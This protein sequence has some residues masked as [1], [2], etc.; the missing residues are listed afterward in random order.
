MSE[1]KEIAQVEAQQVDV[2]QYAIA[3]NAGIDTIERLI[4]Q[5]E[6]VE[7]R[8]AAKAYTSAFNKFSKLCP[9][10]LKTRKAHNTMYAGL[11]ETLNAIEP[12][13][14]ECGLTKSWRTDQADG[15]ITVTCYITHIKGHIETTSLS[16][17]PDT[18]GSKNDAQS[19]GSIVSYL[20]RYTIFAILGLASA[21]QDFDGNTGAMVETIT[22][23]Q[24]EKIAE[25]LTDHGVNTDNFF[26]W[27]KVSKGAEH[28]T[29]IPASEYKS[30]IHKINSTIEAARDNS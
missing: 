1:T 13:L 25:L 14:Q 6:R 20:E 15:T 29:D 24:A 17:A 30:V 12:A 4:V 2:L 9:V 21:D 18:T 11:A 19:V 8:A 10:I 5:Q 26:R 22:S 16:A 28:A 27:L 7:D 23:E 3:N